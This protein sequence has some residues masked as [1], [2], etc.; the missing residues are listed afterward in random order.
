MK[1]TK[2]VLYV[3][4]ITQDIQSDTLEALQ[5]ID[6]IS[7]SF[8]IGLK[9]DEALLSSIEVPNYKEDDFSDSEDSD[10]LPFVWEPIPLVF[11]LI[12]SSG[13][14]INSIGK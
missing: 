5:I 7:D 14:V 12:D 6:A 1:L 2:T 9:I 3:E 10:D 4:S 13:I 11:D 8:S